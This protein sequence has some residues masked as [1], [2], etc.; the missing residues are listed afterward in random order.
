[1][2]PAQTSKQCAFDEGSKV[3][4]VP[5][6]EPHVLAISFGQES[7][8]FRIV[9]VRR[10]SIG[11]VRVKGT[12][13]VLDKQWLSLPVLK[14]SR[15]ADLDMQPW[16]AEVSLPELPGCCEAGVSYEFDLKIDVCEIERLGQLEEP[17]GLM[18][19]ISV[20]AVANGAGVSAPIDP[21][22][23]Q[24][25]INTLTSK[26]EVYLGNFEVTDEAVNKAMLQ[27]RDAASANAKDAKQIMSEHSG[28]VRH[29]ASPTL[30]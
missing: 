26:E 10:A 25:R 30:D 28:E 2:R 14:Q 11:N 19:T 17:I 20:A 4:T 29:T 22:E 3:H 21:K 18:K 6:G 12:S 15:A 7:K 8:H 1:M 9:D 27:L 13:G 5:L 24:R 16:L 23:T